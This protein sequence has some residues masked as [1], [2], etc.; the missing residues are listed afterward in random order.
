[1]NIYALEGHKVKCHTFNAG[2]D[3][4]KEI[5]KEHLEIGK[6]YTI[7]KTIVDSYHTDVWLKEFPNVKF[8]SVFFEDV[9]E[10]SEDE[11]KLHPD[12]NLYH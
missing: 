11:D 2:Y 7:D 4:H 6:E 5:A 1:M 10:Q 9:T 12:Y 8:N 3:Y